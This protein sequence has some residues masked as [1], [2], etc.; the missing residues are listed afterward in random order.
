MS[1]SNAK[2]AKSKT[3]SINLKLMKTLNMNQF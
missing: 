3:K 2:E 1:K